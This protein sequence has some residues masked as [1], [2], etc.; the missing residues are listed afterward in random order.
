MRVEI[1]RGASSGSERRS[2][3]LADDDRAI[4]EAYG[5]MLEAEGYHVT[6]VRDGDSAVQAL[7]GR[8]FDVVITDIVLP[9]VN[10]LI[11]LRRAKALQPDTPVIVITAY[12]LSDLQAEF[13][14][15]GAF[16]FLT[17]PVPRAQLLSTVKV[18]LSSRGRKASHPPKV[19]IFIG[20]SP[21]D[22][23]VIQQ[24]LRIA[25]PFAEVM[26]YDIRKVGMDKAKEYHISGVP[27]VVVNGKF[28]D[29]VTGLGVNLGKLKAA[30]LGPQPA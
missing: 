17:K 16:A 6:R 9:G 21:L 1:S 30:G 26:V 10:G 12:Q 29:C 23:M 13:K 24:V 25:L 28:V 14:D 3:L 7:A 11:L 4:L 19:E 2:I 27:A 20:G 22:E 5:T 8:N 15:S 18:A